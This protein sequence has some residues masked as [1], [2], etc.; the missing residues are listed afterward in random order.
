MAD[1]KHSP[2][3]NR[4]WGRRDP[5]CP[6]CKELAAG[7]APRTGWGDRRRREQEQQ[8]REIRTHDCRAAGCG[9]VCT[10]GDW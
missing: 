10:F 1:T 5:G 8:I 9:V 6:R 2:N 4:A 7:A 3:C